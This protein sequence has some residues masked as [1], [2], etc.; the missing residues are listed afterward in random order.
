MKTAP[1]RWHVREEPPCFGLVPSLE[2]K[3]RES[4]SPED[5]IPE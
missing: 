2:P 4:D 5:S 1:V 3:R